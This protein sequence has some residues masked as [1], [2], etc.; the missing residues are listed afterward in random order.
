MI[1][2]LIIILLIFFLRI[3]DKNLET[4]T[5]IKYIY[6]EYRKNVVEIN[7]VNIFDLKQ[8]M[9]PKY[10]YDKIE[11]RKS[12]PYVVITT[13]CVHPKE[14]DIHV[15]GSILNIGAWEDHVLRPFIKYVSNHS[16]W[17]VID[18]GAQIGQYTLYA[19][20]MG[21]K[22][23]TIEPF[24]DNIQRIHKA[25]TLE[26]I[27]D[28]II[29]IKNAVSNKRNDIKK[30]NF[31]PVNIGGQG[32]LDHLNK[33]HVKNETDKYLVETIIFD[34]IIPYIPYM[35]DSNKEKFK[36]ALIKIDIQGL[37]PYAFENA[38]L[39]FDSIDVRI[40]LME[41]GLFPE[42]PNELEKILK[43][44][45]FLYERNFESYDGKF[46]SFFNIFNK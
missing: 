22:V 17:L 9:L 29:L 15:S 11:C 23:I 10:V 39:L 44:L 18:V 19:A 6:P 25:A 16:D 28:N 3:N 4:K 1:L 32:L 24:H 12:A 45:D 34:D 20:K 8:P 33:T 46:T 36:K 30:L 40:I 21:R 38:K 35:C 2:T 41:W 43:M 37:E 14:K 7:K 42:M 27:T 5:L 26:K 13:L 31:D